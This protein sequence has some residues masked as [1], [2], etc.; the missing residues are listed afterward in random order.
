MKPTAD[1]IAALSLN[2]QA[3]SK[4]RRMNPR[5]LA[6]LIPYQPGQSGN[7]GGKPKRDLAAELARAIF[8]NDGPAIYEAMA[9]SLRKGNAYAFTQLA[10]RAFGKLTE[11]TTVA[12]AN[13]PDAD[14][15]QQIMQLEIDLGI[16]GVIDALPEPPKL[17][18]GPTEAAQPDPKLPD[19]PVGGH[20]NSQ[21]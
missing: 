16:A 10:E 11:H 9:K 1:K 2:A 13:V 8:E 21:Q 4:K 5:S 20:N 15:D 12:F 7:P 18:A 14:L 19:E 6:N 17:P 3:L